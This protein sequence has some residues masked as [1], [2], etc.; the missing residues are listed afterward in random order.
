LID[1]P[2]SNQNRDTGKPR[3]DNIQSDFVLSG[4]GVACRV[5]KYITIVNVGAVVDPVVK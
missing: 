1:S 4:M 5:G 2:W 3:K